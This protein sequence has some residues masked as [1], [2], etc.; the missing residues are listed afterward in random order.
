MAY[1]D[2]FGLIDNCLGV[3]PTGIIRCTVPGA[4]DPVII[5]AV[6]TIPVSITIFDVMVI[7]TAT[8]GVGTFTIETSIAPAGYVALTNAMVCAV[9]NVP[10]RAATL[11]AAQAVVGPADGIE[12]N[13]NAAA[14]EGIVFLMFFLT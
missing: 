11:A 13:K 9:V 8:V 2:L 1:N 10:A 3:A 7:P 14:D 4:G 6:G 5:R 12:V